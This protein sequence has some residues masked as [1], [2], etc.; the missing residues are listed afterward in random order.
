MPG[1]P[2][3]LPHFP[4]SSRVCPMLL[5]FRVGSGQTEPP[6][7]SC[8]APALPAALASAPSR[9]FAL[10]PPLFR[11]LA[12]SLQ[13]RGLARCRRVVVVSVCVCTYDAR[14][15]ARSHT[16]LNPIDVY[17][18]PP[19]VSISFT[20]TVP[21][22]PPSLQ[23]F[24]SVSSL[25]SLITRAGHATLFSFSRGVEAASTAKPNGELSP[26]LPLSLSLCLF[27][28][29]SLGRA[30]SRNASPILRLHRSG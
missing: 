11:R 3:Q 7:A 12:P 24:H 4:F 20:R 5:R 2:R 18:S 10:I 22:S 26:F 14:A 13:P 29:L 21:S 16:C 28:Y 17:T 8:L 30:R 1:H 15:R 27:L 6:S 19:I 25:W 9:H 23:L